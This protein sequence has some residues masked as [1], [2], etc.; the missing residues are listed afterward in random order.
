MAGYEYECLP[1]CGSFRLEGFTRAHTLTHTHQVTVARH[2]DQLV[3]AAGTDTLTQ[4][5]YSLCVSEQLV[6]MYIVK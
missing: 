3:H 1:L 6:D 5:L 2:L 4:I